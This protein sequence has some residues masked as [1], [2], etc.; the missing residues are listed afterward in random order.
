MTVRAAPLG[1]TL[2]IVS[3]M[4]VASSCELLQQVAPP[5]DARWALLPDAGIGP[6]TA[7]FTALVTE[8]AC[9]SGQSSE[10][11]I[12]GPEISYTD[13]SVTITFAVRGIGEANCP[14]NPPTP[15]VVTLEEPLGD[16]TLLDGGTDPPREPPVCTN[17]DFC[18]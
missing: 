18:E 4:L 9:A 3:V 10:G 12:V 1:R 13:E 16:R 15:V 6:E 17:L 14:S 8:V 11:R 7:E 5:G 2:A